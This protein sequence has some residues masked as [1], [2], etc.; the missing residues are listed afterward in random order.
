MKKVT[1]ELLQECANKLMF[2][3]SKEECES[4][5]SDFDILTKQIELIG[6]VDKV[7]ETTPMSFPFDVT[8]NYLRE[9][10]ASTPLDKEEVLKNASEVMDDQIKIPKVVK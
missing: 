7:D 2:H 5:M 10:I 9:D 1:E 4:L 6:E 3:L 8:N